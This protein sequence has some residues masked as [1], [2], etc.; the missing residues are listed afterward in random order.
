MVFIYMRH[1]FI[2]Y[3]LTYLLIQDDESL[4]GAPG[5]IYQKR[6]VLNWCLIDENRTF[7]RPVTNKEFKALSLKAI[8]V[9][10]SNM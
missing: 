9:V 8:I 7:L 2:I 6:S 4:T 3:L 10:M 1:N 5:S